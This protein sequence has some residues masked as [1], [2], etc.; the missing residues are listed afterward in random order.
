[1]INFDMAM[2]RLP[3]SK[4]DRVKITMSVRQVR[5]QHYSGIHV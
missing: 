4:G 5:R 1:V 3:D 2:E